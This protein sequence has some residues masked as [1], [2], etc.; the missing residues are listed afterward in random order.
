MC[1]RDCTVSGCIVAA[2][3]FSSSLLAQGRADIGSSARVG[4]RYVPEEPM[5]RLFAREG[6]D[7]PAVYTGLN[8]SVTCCITDLAHL[9]YKLLAGPPP[10]SVPRRPSHPSA[11]RPLCAMLRPRRQRR[12]ISWLAFISASQ[13]FAGS[14]FNEVLPEIGAQRT[15]SGIF[16]MR[17]RDLHRR[18]TMPTRQAQSAPL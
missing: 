12:P 16:T 1:V 7:V 2:P 17:R 18:G 15:S 5:Y 11:P 6:R 4:N 10:A 8:P 14:A 9:P 3:L 13:P